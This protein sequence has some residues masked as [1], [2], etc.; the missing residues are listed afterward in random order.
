MRKRNRLNLLMT[1]YCVD[2]ETKQTQ[3]TTALMTYFDRKLDT[4]A[5]PLSVEPRPR[6]G[7]T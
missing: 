6:T 7:E 4:R 3:L 2:E 1:Y 5:P